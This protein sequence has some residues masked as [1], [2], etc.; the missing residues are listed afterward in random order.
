M[1]KSITFVIGFL[2]LVSFV[3][4]QSLWSDF[5][6]TEFEITDVVPICD[7]QN[8]VWKEWDD[9]A[10]VLNEWDALTS[11]YESDGAPQI[12]CPEGY[13]CGY[14]LPPTDDDYM[15][16]Y[17]SS[18]VVDYCEDYT[19][20]VECESAPPEVAARSVEI[21]RDINTPENICEDDY[22][23]INSTDPN[24]IRYS[25][26]LCYWDGTQCDSGIEYSKWYC[27]Y[28]GIDP[29]PPIGEDGICVLKKGSVTGNCQ[30]D[31]FIRITW[32]R[33]WFGTGSPPDECSGSFTRNIPCPTRLI[34]FTVLSFALTVV[35]IIGAYTFLRYK[36]RR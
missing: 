29:D 5:I 15:K 26:C 30:E 8:Y 28:P 25:N 9:S 3:Y 34:F 22:I 10:G 16:C 36:K 24:C 1:K 14:M 31:D 32:T 4:A 35:M 17:K 23:E 20:Q 6:S 11:C 13:K 18:A 12:C 33:E 19:D 21:T 27:D 7:R 2:L